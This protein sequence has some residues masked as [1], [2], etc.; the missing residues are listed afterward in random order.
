MRSKKSATLFISGSP[1]NSARGHFSGVRESSRVFAAEGM[2]VAEGM[3]AGRNLATIFWHMSQ[4][5]F[6]QP[7]SPQH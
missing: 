3:E 4:G 5:H 6:V 7:L 2:D 1:W